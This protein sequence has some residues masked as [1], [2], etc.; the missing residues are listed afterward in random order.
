MFGNIKEYKL[1]EIT[2]RVLEKEKW[3]LKEIKK[4][5]PDIIDELNDVID[6]KGV[7]F[8]LG[9]KIDKKKIVKGIY[10]FKCEVKEQE[11]ILT[12]DR[13]LFSEVIRDEVIHQFEDEIDSLLGS[14]VSENM[15]SKAVFRDRE[16]VVKKVKLG[17]YEISV[18][19]LWMF[20]GI[21]LWIL[22]KDVIWFMFGIVFA[23][24][25]GYAVHI[26]GK[27]IS[28]DEHR[29]YKKQEKKRKSRM[30][31]DSD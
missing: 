4:E 19:L 23:F 24:S 6:N 28:L 21:L 7:I 8:A 13:T 17:K 16:F 2:K 3:D 25:F 14:S 15:Y 1:F 27:K 11:K 22:N 26:D 29:R 20:G 18:S 12:F 30:K 5:N 10:I 9:R 31:K